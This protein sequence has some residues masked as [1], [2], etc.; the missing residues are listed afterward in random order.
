MRRVFNLGLGFL[1]VVP[2]AETS[3]ALGAAERAGQP[4]WAVGRVVAGEGVRFR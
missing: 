4:A 2:E 1:V 3:A